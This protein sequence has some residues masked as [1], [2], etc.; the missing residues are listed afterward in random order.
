MRLDRIGHV[1]VVQDER[2]AALVRILVQVVD[3]LGVE[4]RR[5]AL[6]AV[7]HVALAEQELG[8]VGAVLAGD[9]GDQCDWRHEVSRRACGANRPNDTH[10]TDGP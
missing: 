2:A 10:G 3:A 4:Q 9:A 6:D 7:H 8:E 1:A 5:A